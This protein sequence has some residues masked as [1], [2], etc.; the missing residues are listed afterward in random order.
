VN[1][2]L[3]CFRQLLV[4]CLLS[5]VYYCRLCLLK[6]PME[7]SSLLLFLSLGAPCPSAMCPF[8]FCI[9]YPGFVLFFCGVG[10]SLFR[11]LCWFIPRVAVGAPHAAYLLTCWSVSPKQIWSQHLAVQEPSCFLSG[12]WHG[13]PLCGL[14]VQAVRFLLLLG[15]FFLPSVAPVSQQDF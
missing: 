15:G 1:R 11:G 2:Y 5:A 4:T 10:V 3:S 12:T 7:S 9:Y 13:D 8:Q 6:V 14:G